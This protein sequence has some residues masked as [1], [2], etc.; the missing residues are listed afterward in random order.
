MAGVSYLL[1]SL[2]S[3]A[4]Q[5][6][7]RGML[8]VPSSGA[9]TAANILAHQSLLRLGFAS[10][11]IAVPFH[12][13]WAVLFY[14]LFT[15]VNRSVSLLAAFVL[16][17]G[18]VMWTISSLFLLAPLLVLQG[19]GNA[20]SS[21]APEQRHALAMVLLRLNDQAYDVG[22]VFFGLWCVSVGYLIF[23]STFLPRLI[24][25]LYALAGAGYLTLL[26]RP[27]ASYLYPYNLA[28]AGPG[29][30]SLMLWLL[31]KGVNPP[32]WNEQADRS[33]LFLLEDE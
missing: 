32:R 30:I 26:W 6:V 19:G 9:A 11:F 13:A 3:V 1:G 23:W 17:M 8:V 7:I 16:L 22:L 4:G 2:T 31:V 15:P 24:G 20:L 33:R 18:C 5:M 14:D 27:L 12:I 10:S 25:V 29:E 28:L 21:F